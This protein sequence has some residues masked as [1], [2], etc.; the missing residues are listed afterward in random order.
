MAVIHIVEGDAS[1]RT[2]LVRLLR[3]QK[4][5][6]QTYAS[7]E[8]LVDAV[9]PAKSDCV[10][11]DVDAPGI[12]GLE[13]LRQFRKAGVDAPLISLTAKDDEKTRAQAHRLGAAGYFLKPVDG[14]ALLDTIQFVF[15]R[16]DS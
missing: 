11:V 3:S 4:L 8:D 9:R 2:A 6:V 13:L 16:V 7:G 14:Q 12:P 15:D 5:P 10:V 1:V